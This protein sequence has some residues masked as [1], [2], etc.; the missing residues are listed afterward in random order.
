MRFT[1]RMS[2]RRRTRFTFGRKLLVALC[3]AC[4]LAGG[5]V[6]VAA[7]SHGGNRSSARAAY[8]DGVARRLGVSPG[9]LT[10]A[11]QAA[12]AEQ[13]KAALAAG[14]IT[15]ARAAALES[16]LAKGRVPFPGARAGG[17]SQGVRAAASYLGLPASTLR[18]ELSGR[19]LAQIASSTPGKSL[20]GLE[21]ALTAA[22]RERIAT[23]EAKGRITAAEAQRRL[24]R[25][26]ARIAALVQRTGARAPRR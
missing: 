17:R 21:A 16:R 8:I 12:G 23:A 9:A 19:S 13:V 18:G 25:L 15:P 1:K 22:A 6:A 11:M 3:A 10:A 4:L 20:A 14:R 7:T 5:A 26:P 24:G 2:A